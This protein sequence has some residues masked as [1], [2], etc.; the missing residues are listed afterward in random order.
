MKHNPTRPGKYVA[1]INWTVH[2]KLHDE[3]QILEWDGK[4]WKA[5]SGC[6]VV[7]WKKMP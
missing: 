3:W 1:R 2:G 7:D 5:F 4:R 6:R